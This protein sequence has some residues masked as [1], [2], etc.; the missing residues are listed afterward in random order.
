MTKESGAVL[1]RKGSDRITRRHP[2]IFKGHLSTLPLSKPGDLIP[3]FNNRSQTV[4]WG[5]WS[6]G[7]LCMRVLSFAPQRPDVKALLPS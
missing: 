3:L 5:F 2:W 1:N 6:P 7:A 4:A